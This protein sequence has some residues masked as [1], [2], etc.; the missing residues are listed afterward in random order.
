MDSDH[1][2]YKLIPAE[3]IFREKF[4]YIL[5]KYISQG[6]VPGRWYCYMPLKRKKKHQFC[7]KWLGIKQ[8]KLVIRFNNEI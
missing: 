3:D 8:K 6:G 1:R 5:M 7:T 4:N 2:L